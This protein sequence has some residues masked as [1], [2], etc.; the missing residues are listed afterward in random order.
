[1]KNSNLLEQHLKSNVPLQCFCELIP[2]HHFELS[3]FVCEKNGEQFFF[4]IREEQKNSESVFPAPILNELLV[5]LATE[6]HYISLEM[7]GKRD[8]VATL[9]FMDEKII[10]KDRS[11][12]NAV[13]KLWLFIHG[14]QWI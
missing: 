6:K 14:I 9:Y 2:L 12:V 13:M 10:Q 8:W 3:L 5:Q 1:M 7:D 11:A 4:T